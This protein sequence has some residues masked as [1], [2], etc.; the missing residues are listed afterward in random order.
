MDTAFQACGHNVPVC[1]GSG[2]CMATTQKVACWRGVQGVGC[3]GLVFVG[4]E[5]ADVVAL[6][7]AA[8]VKVLAATAKV[9]AASAKLKL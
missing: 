9:M 4:D 7:E 3:G 2:Q 6:V 1:G 8:L 5:T